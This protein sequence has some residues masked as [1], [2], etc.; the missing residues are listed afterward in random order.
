LP[1]AP[2]AVR[3][4]GWLLTQRT[5]ASKETRVAPKAGQTAI[6]VNLLP[7]TTEIERKTYALIEESIR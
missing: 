1:A 5:L 6:P 7:T 2:G 3:L 4:S